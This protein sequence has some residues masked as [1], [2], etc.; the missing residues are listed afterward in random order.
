MLIR[1]S[2]CCFPCSFIPQTPTFAY[3]DESNSWSVWKASLKDPASLYGTMEFLTLFQFQ[4][5]DQSHLENWSTCRC[6][7][8]LVPQLYRH[9]PL[10]P[11]FMLLDEVSLYQPGGIESRWKIWQWTSARNRLDLWLGIQTLSPTLCRSGWW[12][13]SASDN[14]IIHPLSSPN[15]F[16]R[17][18]KFQN[19]FFHAKVVRPSLLIA[20]SA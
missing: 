1:K 6:F 9:L 14:A 12:I 4:V 13:F 8:K 3:A 5:R 18:T 10:F 11:V 20:H 2:I 7:T 15:I 16:V 17:N 19:I